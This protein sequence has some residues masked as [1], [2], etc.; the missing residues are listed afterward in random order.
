VDAGS[1]SENAIEQRE[2]SPIP[3]KRDSLDVDDTP[4]TLKGGAPFVAAPGLNN[5]RR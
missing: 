2:R 5:D 4:N 3:S 1:P